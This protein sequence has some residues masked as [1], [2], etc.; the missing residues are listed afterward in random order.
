MKQIGISLLVM[1]FVA[2]ALPAFAAEFASLLPAE[3]KALM[4]SHEPGPVIVDVR[5]SRQYD[6]AHIAGA[7]S[8]PLAELGKN[9]SLPEVPKDVTL[10]FYC[11]GTT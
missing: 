1:F 3:L 4:E 9:P 11:S 5:S 2:L 6:E 8:I 7:I 10:V